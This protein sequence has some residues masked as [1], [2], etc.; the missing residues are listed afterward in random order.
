L[1]DSGTNGAG[2]PTAPFAKPGPYPLTATISDGGQSV[3]SGVTVTVDQTLTSLQVSPASA[4]VVNGATQQ[5][6]ATALDQFGL[7]LA[8]QPAFTWSIDAGGV[9]MIDNNGL[10]TAPTT[11]V[12][13]GTVRASSGA[14]SA[15]ATVGAAGRDTATFHKGGTAHQGHW[16]GGCETEGHN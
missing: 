13:S 16:Q 14:T 8:T 3:T 10:Y 1:A 6:S 5:F 7:R 9:G 2:P 11:G 12:G 4:T 15:S